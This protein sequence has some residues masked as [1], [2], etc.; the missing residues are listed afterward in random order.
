GRAVH[1]LEYAAPLRDA[2]GMPCGAVG[3]FIDISERKRADTE[4][5]APMEEANRERAKLETML[6]QM[7]AGVL[8][9]EPITAAP[10]GRVILRN[11]QVGRIWRCSDDDESG[12]VGWHADGRPYQP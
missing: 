9:A 8:I 11:E 10:W 4:R 12:P 2:S 5:Q 1:L 3:A 7:P 6:H